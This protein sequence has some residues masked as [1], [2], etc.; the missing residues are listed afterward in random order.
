MAVVPVVAM[1]LSRV[2]RSFWDSVGWGRVLR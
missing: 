1:V 2:I